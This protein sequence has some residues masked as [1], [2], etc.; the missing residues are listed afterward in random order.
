M[1]GGVGLVRLREKIAVFW[2]RRDLRLTDNHGLFQALVSGYQVLPIFI[3]DRH[4]LDALRDQSDRHVTLL[5]QCLTHLQEDLVALGSS[6]WSYYGTVVEAFEAL[7]YDYEIK[8]IYCNR[9]YEPYSEERDRRIENLFAEAGTPFL[10]FKDQCVFDRSEIV[11]PGGEP[12]TLFSQYKR[13]WLSYFNESGCPAYVGDTDAFISISQPYPLVALEEM[14]FKKWISACPISPVEASKPGQPTGASVQLRFGLQ[15]I[16]EILRQMGSTNKD[17]LTPLIWHDFYTQILYHHPW[18]VDRP[19]HGEFER[20]SWRE[21]PEDFHRWRTGLTG[22]PIVDAGMRELEQ[23]GL[24]HHQVRLVAASFLCKHLLIDWRKGEAYFAE[25]LLDFDLAANN[26][27]W[28]WVAGTGCEAFPYFRTFNPW[29]VAQKFDPEM[30]YTKK[31]IPDLLEPTYP[32]PMIDHDFARKR[33]LL[34]YRTGLGEIEKR[35]EPEPGLF[36]ETQ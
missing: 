1:G 15:S 24:M 25:K 33:A 21:N 11:S 16:R 18:M 3:F 4:G 12:S 30:N 6:L 32:A 13:K 29:L 14:G 36:P 28:Q 22:V 34:A 20:I 35:D 7:Q 19:Y 10:H 5:H 27:N 2:F 9:E 31:W 23:T 26:G 8:A 17:R